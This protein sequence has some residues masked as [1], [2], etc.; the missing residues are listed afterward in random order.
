M[1]GIRKFQR[2]TAILLVVLSPLGTNAQSVSAVLKPEALKVGSVG[3][4]GLVLRDLNIQSL[5]NLQP[6]STSGIKIVNPQPSVSQRTSI[7]NGRRSGQIE[8][9]WQIIPLR[10]GNITI[11]GQQIVVEGR[12]YQI[13]PRTL[14]VL[15]ES[16]AERSRFRFIWDLPAKD[17]YVGEAIPVFLK[18]YVR[19]DLRAARPNLSWDLGDGIIVRAA[20]E[21]N[22]INEEFNGVNYTVAVWPLILSPIRPDTFTLESTTNI[23]FQD[24]ANP[25]YN[26]DFLRRQ[27]AQDNKVLVTPPANLVARETPSEGRLPGFNG[28]IGNFE[29]SAETD[30][31]V[32]NAGEPLTLNIILQGTGNFERIAA[33]EIPETD[34]WRVYP[35]K[36]SFAPSDSLG[37]S[38]KKTFSYLLI[39]ADESIV[40][41]PTVPFASFN[42][43]S[44]AYQNLSITPITIDVQ[45]APE[46]TISIGYTTP[47]SGNG[48]TLARPLNTWRPFKA[49]LGNLSEGVRPVV[50]STGF[51]ALQ[52]L[53]FVTF[54]TWAGWNW[55]RQKFRQDERFARRVS[56]S[57][58]VRRSLKLAAEEATNGNA[59]AFY[60]A[61]QRTVQEAMSRHLSRSQSS[62]SLTLLEISTILDRE[63][64]RQELKD[65]VESLFQDAEAMRY[66]G[67]TQDQDRSLQDALEKLEKTIRALP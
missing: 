63:S 40:E 28:A 44:R 35:P 58:A 65:D 54:A 53:L 16:E 50:Q 17:F 66:A 14:K 39:P 10:T 13:P 5:P 26:N 48:S 56:S 38:G 4:Y 61:A 46:G 51:I 1:I 18:A 30:L 67:T 24:P 7:V 42:P 27:I 31:E 12:S 43:Y 19:D 55:R 25:R 45:P 23:T 2:W 49:E 41:T 22:I 29:A 33:P 64:A 52:L 11:P 32:V 34:G 62:N 8:L 47:T 60:I 15:P 21:P 37:Y 6:P 59:E 36:V 3:L 9:T 20:E 57:K